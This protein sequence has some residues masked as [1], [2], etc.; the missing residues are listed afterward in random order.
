MCTLTIEFSR[1]I[2]FV[3]SV[4]MATTLAVKGLCVNQRYIADILYPMVTP[5]ADML[6]IINNISDSNH[7]KWFFLRTHYTYTRPWNHHWTTCRHAYYVLY[8]YTTI[9]DYNK[10]MFIWVLNINLYFYVYNYYIV[11]ETIALRLC[12]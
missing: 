8:Y 4:A 12:V 2:R 11:T 6:Y 10:L 5:P 9:T 7:A 3:F 1:A